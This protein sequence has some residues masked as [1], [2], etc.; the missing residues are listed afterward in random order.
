MGVTLAVERYGNDSACVFSFGGRTLGAE[1]LLTVVAA[2][3]PKEVMILLSQHWIER[4][5]VIVAE[6]WGEDEVW[7]SQYIEVVLLPQTSMGTA[8]GASRT[9][10]V[11]T[12]YYITDPAS[13][14][15][16]EQNGVPAG[17]I[18]IDVSDALS[19]QI[20]AP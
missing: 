18:V 2:E 19:V 7:K 20:R 10:R 13:L 5:R 1:E 4:G 8:R 17:L 9:W 14:G 3:A 11:L 16:A 6:A 12:T 15:E